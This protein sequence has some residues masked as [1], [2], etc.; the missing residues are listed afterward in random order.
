MLESVAGI[1]TCSRRRMARLMHHQSQSEGH[2]Q[3]GGREREREMER[4][5]DE[6][7]RDRDRD[8]ER[9]I[10]MARNIWG[11]LSFSSFFPLS[12]VH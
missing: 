7:E 2:Q 9:E 12:E 8:R 6:R 4:E 11:S 1:A 3:R 5:R 10:E